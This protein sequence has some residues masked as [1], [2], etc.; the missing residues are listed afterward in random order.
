[1]SSI[2]KAKASSLI[3]KQILHSLKIKLKNSELHPIRLIQASK[4]LIG[5]NLDKPNQKLIKYNSHYLDRFNNKKY[6]LDLNYQQSLGEV[7][8][9]YDLEQSFLDRD[10]KTVLNVLQQL[11]LVSSEMHILEYLIEL[12]LKQSG[13]SF[14]IIWSLY[15]SILFLNSYDSNLFLNLATDI[16]LEDEFENFSPSSSNLEFN[17]HKVSIDHI[18]LYAHLL[19]AYN[20]NLI[21]SFKIKSLITSFINRKINNYKTINFNIN[22]KIKYTDLLNNGRYWLLNFIN[23]QDIKNINADLILFLDSIRCLFRFLDKKDHKFIC[24]QFETFLENFNV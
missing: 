12:S 11:S 7:V 9:I 13:K 18:D 6:Y 23:Q 19:E 16:I 17:I 2:D 3:E 14:L 20:S 21:R 10:R 5:L 8:S 15:R 4:S 1:M 22:N 24:F